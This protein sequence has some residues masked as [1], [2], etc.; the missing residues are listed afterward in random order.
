LKS[1]LVKHYPS[2]I[3]TAIDDAIQQKFP[4]R[5]A[6]EEMRAAAQRQVL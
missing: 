4:V 5:L 1:L 3:P 2:H 6:G